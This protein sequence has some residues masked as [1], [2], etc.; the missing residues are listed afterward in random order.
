MIFSFRDSSKHLKYSLSK[1]EIS[2]DVGHVQQSAT[3]ITF[4]R[5]NNKLVLAD[6]LARVLGASCC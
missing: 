2:E 5:N 4:V 3:G 1:D 6:F